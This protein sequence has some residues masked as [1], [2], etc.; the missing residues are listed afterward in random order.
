MADILVPLIILMVTISTSWAIIHVAKQSFQINA[1]FSSARYK[2]LKGALA[3]L[4][5]IEQLVQKRRKTMVIKQVRDQLQ[6]DL[7]EA[8]WLVDLLEVEQRQAYLSELE[9]SLTDREQVERFLS[10]NKMGAIKVFRQQTG[11][12]LR[13][14]RDAVDLMYAKLHTHVS[15]SATDQNASD[16][17]RD[18][19]AAGRKIA[20]IKLYR[21][22][23]GV[24]LKEAKEAIEALEAEQR[25]NYKAELAGRGSDFVDPDELHRV[26][27][28]RG[29]ITAI[30]YYRQ[31]TGVGLKEA[32]EAVEY[33]AARK[34][35]VTRPPQT[36]A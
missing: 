12:N 32:K 18:M 28:E 4:L 24:G 13:D 16:S 21:R 8:R 19:L 17:V 29:K 20:A 30:K 34:P 10:I 5:E 27:R 11:A 33:M 14:A 35:F 31:C 36:M 22:Q 25:E 9:A 6:L 3:N 1:D 2:E 23:T 7:R 15:S 26:L